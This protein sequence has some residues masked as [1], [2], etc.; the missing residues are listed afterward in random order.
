MFSC[1]VTC[2]EIFY[3]KLDIVYFILLS[4]RYLL[5]PEI[6]LSFVLEYS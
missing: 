5:L 4:A 2:L 3:W 1:F 6:F